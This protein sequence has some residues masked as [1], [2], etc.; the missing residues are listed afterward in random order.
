MTGGAGDVREARLYRDTGELV[1]RCPG[2]PSC[3]TNG[4]VLELTVTLTASGSYRTLA[5]VGP[6]A[7]P[8]PSGSLDED[9]RAAAAAG[10][11]VELS[12]AIDVQ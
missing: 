8:E 9:A 11:S 6:A 4:N 7:A 10:A 5:I 2:H 3:I 12:R 1:A